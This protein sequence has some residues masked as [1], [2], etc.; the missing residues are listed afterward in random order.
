[1]NKRVR[2]S[3]VTQPLWLLSTGVIL[4]LALL[5]AGCGDDSTG[6]IIDNGDEDTEPGDLFTDTD[7]P[8]A[9]EDVDPSD[10]GDS[11]PDGDDGGPDAN[12]A[13]DGAGDAEDG[14]GDA[15]DGAGDAE[16]GAGDAE[17]GAGDALDLFDLELDAASDP[18]RRIPDSFE[19]TDLD[20]PDS[21]LV[22]FICDT[23]DLGPDA[24][25]SLMPMS[26]EGNV[27]NNTEFKDGDL[28]LFIDDVN[29]RSGT[30]IY[31]VVY[32]GLDTDDWGG[33][34]RIFTYDICENFPLG[35]E[36]FMTAY[37]DRAPLGGPDSSG[38][39]DLVGELP[40]PLFIVPDGGESLSAI[41][42]ELESPD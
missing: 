38:V 13:E 2:W 5:L 33:S 41:N 23:P 18:D 39:E 10:S 27:F 35:L 26:I 14:A 22:P 19:D 25:E 17:D 9:G 15:E 40:D 29:P 4:S 16:D 42:I 7:A 12:D 21:D 8:D 6:T 3:G 28:Y 36:G 30:P 31:T 37:F 1:M 34:S 11:G 20:L 32:E 24:G